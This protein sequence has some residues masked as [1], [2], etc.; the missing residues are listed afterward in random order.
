MLSEAILTVMLS[1]RPFYG[2]TEDSE[3]RRARLT[4]LAETIERAADRAACSGEYKE[5]KC[6][7]LWRN[8]WEL[9]A[10]LVALGWMESRFA[11]YVGEDRCLDGPKQAR[12][13]FDAETGKPRAKSYWQLWE[14]ACPALW[15]AESGSQ[16]AL[17]HAAWCTAS[18]LVLSKRHC[19]SWEGAFG[20]YAGRGCEWSGGQQRVKWMTVV[21]KKLHIARER[22]R[23]KKRANEVSGI[24]D[25]GHWHQGAL[26]PER[27]VLHVALT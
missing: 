8:R 14:V 15:K 6:D 9:S 16:E 5:K 26:V 24:F 13:D 10:A 11:Q 3:A 17:N 1:F 27:S 19:K 2:D 7:A 20:M 18:R 4:Q 12:C 23:A 25:S 21:F 22:I